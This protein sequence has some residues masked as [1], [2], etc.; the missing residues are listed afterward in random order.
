MDSGSNNPFDAFKQ[1]G[2]LRQLQKMF[3]D[4]FFKGM[5]MPDMGSG[6]KDMGMPAFWGGDDE[7]PR[8]DVYEQGSEVIAVLEIPGLNKSTDVH[9]SVKPNKLIV[10]GNI[11]SVGVRQD[12]MLLAERHHGPFS[13]EVSL[14]VTVVPDSVRASYKNGLLE[15]YMLKEDDREDQARGTIPIDFA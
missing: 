2:Q 11:N 12:K 5:P 6:L 8:A 14:P 3:G 9:L 10:R 13:R 1:L 7:F 4:N 15:V